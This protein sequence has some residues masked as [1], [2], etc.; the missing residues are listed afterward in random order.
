MLQDHILRIIG[1]YS[2]NFDFGRAFDGLSGRIPNF[3]C[4]CFTRK[5]IAL[6]GGVF[7]KK[8]AHVRG[9]YL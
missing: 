1:I 7:V 2:M 4:S 6:Q 9:E 3:D 5:D 8:G